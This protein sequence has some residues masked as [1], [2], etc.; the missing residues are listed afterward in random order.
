MDNIKKK[1]VTLITALSLTLNALVLSLDTVPFVSSKVSQKFLSPSLLEVEGDLEDEEHLIANTSYKILKSQQPLTLWDEK[2]SFTEELISLKDIGD[3]E[4]QLNNYPRAFLYLGLIS[5]SLKTNNTTLFND[6]KDLFDSEL[7]E[8]TMIKRIDQVPLGLVSLNLYKTTNQDKYLEY[9]QNT[10]NYILDSIEDDGL[11]SYRKGQRY[12]FEDTLG[13]I[14][15][16]LIEF[17]EYTDIDCIEILDKQFKY[18]NTFGVNPKTYLPSHA[19]NREYNTPVGSN[20]WGRGIGWYYL[21]LSHYYHHTGKMKEQYFGLTRTLLNLRD[22]QG[23]WTQFPGSSTKTDMS[24]TTLYIYSMILNQPIFTKKEVFSLLMP[25][26]DK[27]GYILETS[28]DTYAANNYSQS[29]GKS[30]LSQGVLL[31]IL[32]TYH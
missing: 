14:T 28:G 20:N 17:D 25:Y 3:N 8:N 9:S 15:P 23:V 32:S 10:L 2:Q 19:I 26:I 21:A 22:N 13:L 6:I 11:I 5:F 16:F 4:Y 1:G 29:F 12:I 30:E 27:E 31:L 18:Y 7:E 24:A